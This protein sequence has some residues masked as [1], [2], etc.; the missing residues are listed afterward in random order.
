MRLLALLC[1][2]LAAP[3]WAGDFQSVASIRAAA[4]STLDPATDGEAS[5]DA[6]LRL[7]A[8][9]VAL[10]ARGPGNLTRDWGWAPAGGAELV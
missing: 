4:L 8:C 7:P 6:G 2:L 1:L 10:Q 5:V 9:P 3:A